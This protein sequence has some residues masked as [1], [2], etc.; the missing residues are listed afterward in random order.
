[1]RDIHHII[2]EYRQSDLTK[3]VCLFV[4]FRD[5]RDQFTE[6]DRKEGFIEL[7]GDTDAVSPDANEVKMIGKTL[8]DRLKGWKHR[9]K[10]A[11]QASP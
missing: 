8:M 10:G 9:C 6:I 4:E 7:E 2:E 5:L 3:R 11:F 1:M